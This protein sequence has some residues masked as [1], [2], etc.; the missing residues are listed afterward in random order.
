[1]LTTWRRCRDS[2][3]RLWML[4][5][6]KRL[7]SHALGQLPKLPRNLG[8]VQQGLNG[9]SGTGSGMICKAMLHSGLSVCAG[10]VRV[11]GPGGSGHPE[12]PGDVAAESGRIPQ[13]TIVCWAMQL[14][15]VT[16]Q[17]G[18]AEMHHQVGLVISREQSVHRY[19]GYAVPVRT[20]R[21]GIDTRHRDGL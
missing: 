18:N 15:S 7:Q 17:R 10:D 16:V 13:G 2:S 4:W 6:R 5:P 3:L 20:P 9:T 1:M 12:S 8:G 21:G 19:A 11:N 14:L